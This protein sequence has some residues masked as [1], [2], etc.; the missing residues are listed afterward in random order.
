MDYIEA[1]PLKAWWLVPI[2]P[3]L[4]E[5]EADGSHEARSVRPAWPTGLCKGRR[6]QQ[7]GKRTLHDCRQLYNNEKRPAPGQARW[8]TL[9]FPTLWEAKSCYVTQAAVQWHDLSSLQ[10]P[11][12]RFKRFSCLSLLSSWDYGLDCSGTISAHCKLHLLGSSDSPASASQR[13]GFAMLAMLILNSWPQ[14]MHRPRPS[15]TLVWNLLIYGFPGESRLRCYNLTGSCYTSQAG[16]Q[17]HD[18]THCNLCLHGLKRGFRHVDHAGLELLTSSDP[19]AL[20]SQ[21]IGII[22][23]SYCAQPKAVFKNNLTLSPRLEC[24]GA[25]SAHCNLHLPGSSDSP[26][27]ASRATGITDSHHHTWLTLH[28]GRPRQADHLR[29]GVRDQSDETLLAG[30]GDG[31]AQAGVQWHDLG[32]LQPLPPWSRFKQ[33]S[34]L[35]LLKM[36]FHHVGQ[37]DLE[38]LA[39]CDLPALASQ[40]AGITGV[41]HHTQPAISGIRKE[42]KG[43]DVKNVSPCPSL[44]KRRSLVLSLRLECSGTIIAHC[45]LKL[46]G[47]SNPPTSA[48]QGTGTTGLYHCAQLIFKHFVDTGSHCVTQA[49]LKFLASSDP[50]TSASQSSGIIGGLTLSPKLEY[51]GMITAHCS[52]SLPGSNRVSLCHQAGGQWHNLG[53]LQPPTPFQAILLPQPPKWSLI[54]LPRLEYSGTISTDCNVCLPGSSNSPT[55]TSQVAG[56]RGV[57]R[58]AWLIFV[59]LV[60]T[61]F[62]H[63][64]QAGLKLLT[65]GWSALAGS[66]LTATSAPKVQSILRPQLLSSW[67]YRHAPPHLANFCI[68]SRC[69]VSPSWPGWS[70]TPDL[71]GSTRLSLPKWNLTLLPRLKCSGMILAHCNF[72]LLNSNDSPAS[73]SPVAWITSACHHAQL[74]LVFLVGMGFHHVGRASLEFLTSSDPPGLAS[75]NAGITGVNHCT[76]LDCCSCSFCTAK[77]T[78]SRVHRQPTEQEKIFVNYASDKGLISSIYKELKFTREKQPH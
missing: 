14:A 62:Y 15:K 77:E 35:S 6:T 9:S 8:L 26:A 16:V 78:I 25:I 67:N 52:L 45:H 51:S 2:I 63:V 53:S 4:W 41:S 70:R 69:S 58:Y 27:S 44:S 61:R 24:S 39:S 3:A 54:L 43:K 38:L 29:S 20:A 50:P 76:R 34:Y 5:A 33:F 32:S 57:H 73:V 60:E 64:G 31:V 28:F 48:S 21:S 1:Q 49:G 42:Q 13:R 17:W 55:S 72:H 10:P 46:M 18:V 37:A 23:V 74:L 12:P 7:K 59:F 71:K 11:P 75:Q 40:S 56:T 65:S 30:C 22:G 47:S 36:A 68:F 66:G 19:P